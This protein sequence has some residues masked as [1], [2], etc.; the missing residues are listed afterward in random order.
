MFRFVVITI[1]SGVLMQFAP[2]RAWADII[3]YKSLDLLVMNADLVIRGEVTEIVSKKVDG[4]VWDRVS[5]KVAETI[6]GEKLKEVM[7]EFPQGFQGDF[8][9]NLRGEVLLCLNTGPFLAGPFQTHYVLLH[10]SRTIV[11][12]GAAQPVQPVFS[13]DFKSLTDPKEILKAAHAA[14]DDKARK[15][16]A[17]LEWIVQGALLKGAELSYEVIYPDSERVRSAA[18]K[19]NIK[20]VPLGE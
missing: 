11:L 20:L 2:S 7:F 13:L 3:Q 17:T 8:W 12:N 16:G 1:V 10:T 6:K 5:V 19:Q 9:R 14:V 15:P 4:A 18:K